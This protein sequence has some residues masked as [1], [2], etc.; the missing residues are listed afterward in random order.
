MEQYRSYNRGGCIRN[1][2]VANQNPRFVN[3]EFSRNSSRSEYK[4]EKNQMP[5]GMAYVP[6]QEFGELYD[7]K[8]GLMEGTMFPELNLIFCGVRGKTK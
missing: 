4:P 3:N 6:M 5:V 8:K 1:G 2:F 7:T